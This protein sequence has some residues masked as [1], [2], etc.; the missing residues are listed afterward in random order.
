MCWNK[1][2]T[3]REWRTETSYCHSLCHFPSVCLDKPLCPLS[4][5]FPG[6]TDEF[7]PCL[8]LGITLQVPCDDWLKVTGIPTV[9]FSYC[10]RRGY[11]EA[12]VPTAVLVVAMKSWT[13]YF[14]AQPPSLHLWRKRVLCQWTSNC[15][16]Q[17][18]DKQLAL[19]CKWVSCFL[20]WESLAMKK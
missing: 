17:S 7:L 2:W 13:S 10:H 5:S 16:Y 6:G 4:L 12:Q 9:V 1:H 14:F 20:H 3:G 18:G 19:E 8:L 15:S 11:Q